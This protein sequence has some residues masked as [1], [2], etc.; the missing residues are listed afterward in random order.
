MWAISTDTVCKQTSTS[1]T[2]EPQL[3]WLHPYSRIMAHSLPS[4]LDLCR[5]LSV[6][7]ATWISVFEDWS[8]QG[9]QFILSQV[10]SLKTSQPPPPLPHLHGY[11][12][13][14]FLSENQVHFCGVS[15]FPHFQW[16]KKM[17]WGTSGFFSL[18][19]TFPQFQLLQE[20]QATS[21]YN[22]CHTRR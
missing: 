9:W 11:S 14:I 2:I 21:L 3:M 7:V 6:S 20:W 5:A 22:L 1:L 15:N 8:R 17:Q 16:Q 10:S 12:S 18:N 19:Q 13:S 4:T